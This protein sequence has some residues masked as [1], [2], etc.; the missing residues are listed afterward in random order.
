MNRLHEKGL[1]TDGAM[2]EF[3]K[4][5][6]N[7]VFQPEFDDPRYSGM[8]P[9]ALG[10]AMMQ[11]IERICTNPTDEDRQ[12]FPHIAGN[13]NH[14]AVLRDVWANYRDESFILQFL[15]PHLVRKFGLF[16]VMDDAS[17][18]N[19]RVEAIHDERGYR[20]IKQ[21][22]AKHY[23]VS[24]TA[25]DIQVVDVNLAGDRKLI[26]QHRA[27]N[28]VLL[29]EKDTRHVL[30]HL[31]DLWGYD[32]LMR[33]IDPANDSVLKEHAVSPRPGIVQIEPA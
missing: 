21:A 26:L 28:R 20:K 22:L 3:L 25:P 11:D 9:Y 1:L 19:L 6:T 29:D 12:W 5:H 23:D 16:H 18:P 2:V 15:S 31:A 17:E 4:S 33:E 24:W 7:V 30:Q 8:N 32:V 27:L 10:F 14:M 13:G